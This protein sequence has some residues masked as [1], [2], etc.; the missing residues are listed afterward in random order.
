MS[1]VDYIKN[2][3]KK[4]VENP[5]ITLLFVV[6]LIIIN[7]FTSFIITTSNKITVFLLAI[8]LFL[9]ICAFFS[10]WFQVVKETRGEIREKNYFAIF[11]EGT[12]KNL[13]KTILGVVLYIIAFTFFVFIARMIA[14][15]VFGSLDFLFVD[16]QSI[17]PD[18]TSLMNYF[19]NLSDNQKY[20]ILGWQMSFIWTLTIFNFLSLFYFP[21]LIY[22]SAKNVFVAPFLALIENLIFTFK[23]FFYILLIFIFLNLIH[24]FLAVLNAL[25]A[26]NPIMSLLLLFIYIYFAGFVVVL[27]F[28]YYE[29][30]NNSI[31][32]S[33]SVR[34]DK[35]CD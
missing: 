25:F 3:F 11:L 4:V 18:S 28:N 14:L 31:N 8:C 10:G 13:V 32:R 17:A 16:I 29:Q 27:I 22:S 5:S 23:N 6:F 19:N 35:S 34:E 2:S 24:F 1:L 30:K 20:I 21:A 33:D 15:K 7:F 12:G 26:S 9:F